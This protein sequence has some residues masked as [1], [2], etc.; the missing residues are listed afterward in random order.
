MLV[1][2]CGGSHPVSRHTPT[3][4]PT[5]TPV[6]SSARQSPATGPV[7]TALSQADLS[8]MTSVWIRYR[9]SGQAPGLLGYPGLYPPGSITVG[10]SSAALMPDGGEWAIVGFVLADPSTATQDQQ[11][12]MQDGGNEGVYFRGSSGSTWLLRG[13]ELGG[14]VSI[15]QIGVPPAVAA[16]WGIPDP[17]Q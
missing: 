10:K 16:L 4:P 3:P 15:P 5:A 1:V 12:S 9:E 13:L 11:V 2:A 6:P 8:T 7:A 14:C 17:C